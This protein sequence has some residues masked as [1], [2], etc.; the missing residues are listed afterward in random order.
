MVVRVRSSKLSVVIF[1]LLLALYVRSSFSRSVVEQ[2]RTRRSPEEDFGTCSRQC[3]V[4]NVNNI[5]VLAPQGTPGQKGH[6]GERGSRGMPGRR[7]IQGPPGVPGVPG[8]RGLKGAPGVGI[9]PTMVV[10]FSVARSSGMDKSDADQPVV[11][12]IVHT[13]IK[14]AYDVR[15]G[16]FVAPIGGLYFFSFTA[17]KG[18]DRSG[19]LL[20]LM[21]DT[22]QATG[23]HIVSVY[24]G[25]RGDYT[26][27][28]NSAVL[29]LEPG[30][31][32]WVRLG[33][34]SQ[35][36][37]DENNYVTFSGFL[38]QPMIMPKP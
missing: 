13:N 6:P 29:T 38:I 7:G 8:P 20:S 5:T 15:T 11:Y 16:K 12:D 9:L 30:D 25:P 23:E 4:T 35:L 22:F 26:S 2:S 32:I 31:E 3:N 21:R 10:G 37:S 19:C 17:M 36:F 33:T 1:S 14:K 18:N 27:T 34:G 24:N 28:C